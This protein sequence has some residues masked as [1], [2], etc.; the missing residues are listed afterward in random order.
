MAKEIHSCEECGHETVVYGTNRREAERKLAWFQSN[1]PLCRECEGK[2]EYEKAAVEAIALD[3]P[4]LIGT[5]AQ[6]EWAQRIRVPLLTSLLAMTEREPEN[7]LAALRPTHYGS[8]P[9]LP[10]IK[11]SVAMPMIDRGVSHICTI[12]NANWWIDRARMSP[13]GVLVE[14][15]D[16]LE[17]EAQPKAA[18]ELREAVD[19]EATLRPEKP[20]TETIARFILGDAKT[21][22]EIS[23]PEK[24][25][26]FREAVK[27]FGFKWSDAT[28]RWVMTTNIDQ[29]DAIAAEVGAHLLGCG[30]VI[31]V[32]DNDVR[33]AIAAGDVTKSEGRRID[34]FG[35]DRFRVDWRRIDGDF[36]EDVRKI[37]GSIWSRQH[38][39]VLIPVTSADDLRD[40]SET[41]SFPL[42]DLAI[43]ATTAFD[44]YRHSGMVVDASKRTQGKVDPK[45]LG[46]NKVGIIDD[47]LLDS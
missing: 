20:V 3:L 27:A 29:R 32:R 1:R 10:E 4:P 43:K 5:Q 33:E 2:K 18:P 46:R 44:E 30:F 40:F 37:K 31:R 7:V 21:T 45:T 8:A 42:T 34:W 28:K 15:M 22:V 23:F 19:F 12:N 47:S 24:N 38:Q 41:F 11:E 9:D 6:L 13:A 36:Y 25:D 26:E 16:R 39:T 35:N 17:T 14:V